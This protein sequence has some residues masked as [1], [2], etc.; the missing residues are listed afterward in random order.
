MIHTPEID[1]IVERQVGLWDTL[2]RSNAADDPLAGLKS[3]PGTGGPWVTVSMQLGSLGAALADGV[4]AR[5][6][7]Q[8]FNKAI[9]QAIAS[10]T[11]TRERILSR[12]D[13]QAVGTLHDYIAH[14]FVA[15]HLDRP[16]YLVEMV[17]VLWTI[18]RE[19]R[20]VIV[21][22][23]A[24][25]LLDPQCGVRVRVVAPFEIRAERIAR[26]ENLT[27]THAYRRL[28]Q[29]D[30]DRAAFV[31]QTFKRDI[32]EV[33]GYDLVVNTGALELGA[34]V[35]TVVAALEHKIGTP[36]SQ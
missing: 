27:A 8:V 10:K 36:A 34:A 35:E 25:W 21:G 15:D 5:L 3:S 12:L 26:A 4:G 1:H 17:K 22:R 7:W 20:A 24:N 23:G 29:D 32:D 6:G 31:R 14:L 2:Q 11:H 9:V 18:A 16:A 28:K 30:T 19:G 13:G 33:T